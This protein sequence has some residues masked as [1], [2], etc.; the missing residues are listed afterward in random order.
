MVAPGQNLELRE[1]LIPPAPKGGALV[2]LNCCTI[3]RSD[4]HTWTGKR[5]TETPV[6]LG[7]EAV[8]T[9]VELGKEI[10]M[11]ADGQNLSIGDRVTW[12][13]YSS[14]GKCRYCCDFRLPMKCLHLRKYG[15]ESCDKPP[16][17]LGG[18]AEYCMIDAGTKLLRLPDSLPDI[19]AAP[20]NCAVAT[21]V[22]G[23][24]AAEL[25][26]GDNVLIQGTGALG[27]YAAAF[28]RYVGCHR[29]IVADMNPDRLE[30]ARRFGATDGIDMSQ[31]SPNQLAHQVKELTDGFGVDCALELAGV[32]S[33]IEPGLASLRKGGRYVEIG[34]VFPNAH[35]T[36]DMSIVLFNLLTLRGVH[37]YDARHLRQAIVFL[38]DTRSLFPYEEIVGAQYS[39]EE[40]NIA[41]RAAKSGT[42]LRVAVQCK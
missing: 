7:H 12:T 16:H 11:D 39:L 1:F 34:C 15:H 9:I 25:R 32:P 18:F 38:T 36:I 42:A 30:L 6:I 24:Q 22:A 13:L 4:L 20:A 14:C 21:I 2:R 35:A 28:A 27:C 19:V 5:P 33:I 8:G 37:N 17:L 26:S 23:W 3:C 40:V 29:I 31:L 10:S 41:L